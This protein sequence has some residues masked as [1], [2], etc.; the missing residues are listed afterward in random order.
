MLINRGGEPR[1]MGA[2][3]DLDHHSIWR[4][5]WCWAPL[6]FQQSDK[7]LFACSRVDYDRL[8]ER[9]AKQSQGTLPCG[10]P[11]M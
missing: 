5:V 7:D 10:P 9:A 4:C 11:L 3:R 6:R 1:E 8:L 2:F